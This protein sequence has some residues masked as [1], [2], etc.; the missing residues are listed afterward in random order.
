MQPGQGEILLA[1]HD[2]RHTGFSL[3]G[4]LAVL[5][6]VLF[7]AA[8]IA[9]VA[10][11]W[12]AIARPVRVLMVAVFVLMGLMAAVIA[13][14]RRRNLLSEAAL[15]FALLCHGAGL[16]LVAQIYHISGDEGDFLITWAIG[17]LVVSLSFSSPM[18][19]VGAGVLGIY[20]F[21][22]E[23]T[24]PHSAS[25]DHGNLGNLL[26]LAALTV[27]IGFAAFRSNSSLAGHMTA[28]LS[29]LVLI[30]MFDYVIGAHPGY[31][32]AAMG[33]LAFLAGSVLPLPATVAIARHGWVSAYGAVLLLSGLGLLQA[34]FRDA[35]L[36]TE[37]VMA[38]LILSLSVAV[39]AVA[40]ETNRFVRWFAYLGFA[41]ETL[42]VVA[43]TLG[44]LLGSSGF[45]FL[46]GA[47][48]AIV[49][50]VVMKIEK[51][52]RSGQVSS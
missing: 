50:F 20:F 18:A 5:A 15:V 14:R 1:D 23:T 21:F 30:W 24:F 12:E 36:T 22:G 38:A 47:L 26:K 37:I 2:K 42:Y 46:G 16:A 51:H 25:G 17:V 29:I 9:L 28:V 6:A 49:A 39:L 31:C 44:S 13:R 32:L 3:S 41:A 27:V 48:L 33:S 52:Y 11:N 19:A 10:A 35:S 45:L 8:V 43:V 4:V 34:D 40:G 7:G